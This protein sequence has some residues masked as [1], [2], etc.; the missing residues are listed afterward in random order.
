[1]PDIMSM[2][3]KKL[4]LQG[5]KS[6]AERTKIV[7]HPGITAVVGPNGTGKSNLVDAMLWVLGGHRQKTVRGDRTEDVIFNGNA[8]RPPLNMAD[9]V[10]IL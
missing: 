5:F 6:F 7:F 2:I 9:A 1:M 10:L 4:E 3:I 8:K